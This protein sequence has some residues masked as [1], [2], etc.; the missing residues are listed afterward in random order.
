[1]ATL[2]QTGPDILSLNTDMQPS[3]TWAI[4]KETNRI[5]GTTDG[6]EAVKQASDIILNTERY[7]WQIFKPYSGVEFEF[8]IGN[9]NSYVGSELYRQISE[10][11]KMDDRIT[12]ITDFTFEATGNNLTV[13]FTIQSAYG[14]FEKEV[15]I[16]D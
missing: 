15:I 5:T 10:A 16:N 6:L 8:L 1:M 3:L 7:R 9:N 2:P 14:D 11:L 12:G 13:N 4:D